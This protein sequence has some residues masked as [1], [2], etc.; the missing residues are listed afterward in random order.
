MD[1]TVETRS[2]AETAADLL[3]LPLFELDPAHWRL[4]TPVA[5]LDEAAG[6]PDRAGARRGRLPRQARRDAALASGARRSRAKRAP[7]GR[8]RRRRRASAPMSRARSP[9]AWCAT[10]SSAPLRAWPC[11]RPRARRL[12]AAALA[13]ALAEGAGLGALPLRPLSHEEP[14]EGGAARRNARAR[15]SSVPDAAR[16]AGRRRAGRRARAIPEPGARPLERAAEPL[17]PAALAREARARGTR[18]RR[19]RARARARRAQEA[20]ASAPCSRWGK[21]ARTSRA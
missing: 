20:R 11:S 12:K 14:E 4:P 1:V 19:A 3:A 17:P 6:G 21:A 13:Q 9:R 5:A 8:A 10:A 18:G 15:C 2:P 16:G 7:A